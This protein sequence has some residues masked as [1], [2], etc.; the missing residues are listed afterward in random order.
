MKYEHIVCRINCEPGWFGN[1][2]CH[3]DEKTDLFEVASE[4]V[5]KVTSSYNFEIRLAE[6]EKYLL[7]SMMAY[8]FW[9]APSDEQNMFMIY[10][11]LKAGIL[12]ESYIE[13][14][15]ESDLDRLY[16][17]LEEKD[18]DHTALQYYAKY[19]NLAGNNHQKVINNTM[20]HIPQYGVNLNGNFLDFLSVQKSA[21][22]EKNLQKIA[23]AFISMMDDYPNEKTKIEYANLQAE[24]YLFIALI[25]TAYYDAQTMTFRQKSQ[26]LTISDFIVFALGKGINDLNKL[27][28]I[29]NKRTKNQSN[30][31]NVN[32]AIVYYKKYVEILAHYPVEPERKNFRMLMLIRDFFR[33]FSGDESE[34]V[35]TNKAETII[36]AESDN[37][38]SS[39]FHNKNNTAD[40]IEVVELFDSAGMSLLFECLET[41]EYENAVYLLLTPY[42]ENTREGSFC[43]TA[44]DVFIMCETKNDKDEKILETVE[45]ENI[46]DK[47]FQIFKKRTADM[48]DFTD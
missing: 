42:V 28:A 19:K 44:S 11:L 7:A 29:E 20:K 41:I 43:R 10:E 5:E 37:N 15:I 30:I 22:D 6:A 13:L 48:F 3:L 23:K 17:M 14:N 12:S 36:S 45:D 18:S 9:E 31:K 34:T 1:P 4:F 46:L 33:E 8:L 24:E 2:F 32:H 21:S 25:Y 40:E 27:V 47:V 26:I 39:E 35:S 38:T 16:N